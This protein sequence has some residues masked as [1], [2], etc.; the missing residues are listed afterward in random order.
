MNK[1]L[2]ALA[3][4]LA[5]V[6]TAHAANW[7][8]EGSHGP[9]H[10]GEFASECAQ[11]KNQSPID[12]QSTVQAE[13]AKL[14]LDYNGKAISLTNNGHTLQTSLEGDNNLLV[15]GKSFN[16]KQ[17]HFHT[18][19]ENHVDGKSYP[20]EAHYV[21]AD[22]QGNLAVVAVFFEEGDANPALD[23]LLDKVP[24]KDSN[25]TISAPF[26][27][28]ALIPSEKDY[29]R[30][31]GSLTTPPCS[32]GVRWLVLKDPQTISAAQIATFEQAMGENNRPVQPLNARLIL[33]KQ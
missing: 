33:T 5:L 15:D 27:A 4:S 2:T 9:E 13:L 1:S 17:F 16:L 10:W 14:E 22:E 26:D 3:L 29:Y 20:L 11:G 32:E 31:N 21:H 18:P 30:F 24:A 7:G 12:I 8:Y 28:S 25:V 6:G 23:K 19:S